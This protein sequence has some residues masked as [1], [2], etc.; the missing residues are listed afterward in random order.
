M[1][2][3]IMYSALMMILM[4]F[5]VMQ[6]SNAF[7][8][9][10]I[11]S[12]NASSYNEDFQ[13]LQQEALMIAHGTKTTVF[14][15]SDN[16]VIE[17]SLLGVTD[18]DPANVRDLTSYFNL[19]ND[20]YFIKLEYLFLRPST[21]ISDG[22]IVITN[23]NRVF[24][25]GQ[26]Y[27][28]KLGRGS[29]SEAGNVL[30]PKVVDLPFESNESIIKIEETY[31]TTYLLTSF[32]RV[33]YTGIGPNFTPNKFQNFSLSS[34]SGLGPNELFVDMYAG[35]NTVVL[36]TNQQQF[37]VLGSNQNNLFLEGASSFTIPTNMT[38]TI[39]S[40]LNED[41][42]VVKMMLK[43]N[44]FVFYTN[45][46]RIFAKGQNQ[47]GVFGTG[48][49]DELV[50]LTDITSAYVSSSD[51]I[52]DI[53]LQ[54]ESLFSNDRDYFVVLLEDG[55]LL[56]SGRN[57][58]F[59]LDDDTLLFSQ[60]PVDISSTFISQTP[61]TDKITLM[62]SSQQSF[63][64]KTQ[65]NKHFVV[66][67]V[68]SGLNFENQK[69]PINID[70]KLI[71]S[72]DYDIPFQVE[73][74]HATT[75][76]SVLITKNDEIYSAGNGNFRVLLDG[77]SRTPISDFFSGNT[78]L[79]KNISSFEIKKFDSNSVSSGLL[80]E[81]GTLVTWGRNWSSF[82]YLVNPFA[83]SSQQDIEFF[84]LTSAFDLNENEVIIDYS[85]STAGPSSTLVYNSGVITNTGRIFHW[86]NQ[87]QING[88][89]GNQSIIETSLLP[90]VTSQL[91]LDEIPVAFLDT[92]LVLTNL[93]R[94]IDISEDGIYDLN[95]MN[96][97]PNDEVPIKYEN[98]YMLSDANHLYKVSN[99][100]TD[101]TQDI[102]TAINSAP[103]LDNSTNI[104]TFSFFETRI[105]GAPN[106]GLFVISEQ[107]NLYEIKADY[108]VNEAFDFDFETTTDFLK[109]VSV[110][111]S[112]DTIDSRHVL[113]LTHEGFVY[114]FGANAEGQLGLGNTTSTTEF[115]LVNTLD[116]TNLYEVK[117]LQ[118]PKS[119][120]YT[121]TTIPLTILFNQDLEGFITDIKINDT[122]YPVSSFTKLDAFTYS[123]ELTN[124]FQLFDSTSVTVSQVKLN[125][126]SIKDLTLNNTAFT[127][128]VAENRRL[129]L[130]LNGGTVFNLSLMS[131]II[132]EG[133][134]LNDLPTPT[135]Q[136]YNFVGW[137]EDETL[138]TEFTA[139]T[140]PMQDTTL[141]AKWDEKEYNLIFK[142]ENGVNNAAEI[143]RI[144][145]K[146]GTDMSTVIIPD[147]PEAIG[148][149]FQRWINL[150]TSTMPTLD[151]TVVADFDINSYEI[152]FVTNLGETGVGDVQKTETL[153]FNVNISTQR[154]GISANDGYTFMGWY[155]TEDFST[156]RVT[157][158]PASDTTL[159]AQ[160]LPTHYRF[161]YYN[162]SNGFL[163]FDPDSP[164]YL[165]GD[166][167]SS[168]VTPDSLTVP[169][170]T[171]L[172]W[173]YDQQRTKEIDFSAPLIAQ[174]IATN[175]VTVLFVYAKF[176]PLDYNMTFVVNGGTNI[177]PEIFGFG[178][179][180]S[181]LPSPTKEGYTFTGWYTDED[182]ATAF[183]STTMPS[184]D[185]V[186]YAKYETGTFD[187][188]FKDRL[189]EILET[190]SFLFETDL[191]SVVLPTPPQVLGYTFD[192]WSIELPNIMPGNDLEIQA[193]YTAKIHTLTLVINNGDNNVT[194][195]RGYN[196]DLAI[197]VV[198][199]TGY[200]FAG[201][202]TNIELDNVLTFDVMP[203]DN[204]TLYAKW[205]INSY[206][207]SFDSNDGSVV[208]P[209]T[210]VYDSVVVA[211]DA[212]TRVGFTF[213]GWFS[214]DALTTAFTFDKVPAEN[215]TLYAKWDINSYTIS[216]ELDGGQIN[217]QQIVFTVESEPFEITAATKTNFVFKGWYTDENF[218]QTITTFNPLLNPNDI[219]LYALYIS[220]TLDEFITDIN[221]L[222]STIAIEDKE[223]VLEY[224]AI[225][226][227]LE[228]DEQALIPLERLE[229]ALEEIST[230]EINRVVNVIEEQKE[231]VTLEDESSLKAARELYETLTEEEKALVTNID[232]LESK[233]AI[234]EV[235]KGID[236]VLSNENVTIEDIEEVLIVYNNLTEEQK[237][238][239]D[240][241]AL[242]ALYELQDS[243]NNTSM[244]IFV[245]LL[246]L[247]LL[248]AAAYSYYRFVYKK[249]IDTNK[250]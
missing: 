136:H 118:I 227:T 143:T 127:N 97:L 26:E 199:K 223:L 2:K 190:Q 170:G 134:T 69:T 184:S 82:G 4:S 159:Y 104:K 131:Y 236:T 126:G 66:G 239:V 226:N 14:I 176:I 245:W 144:A 124:E 102:I 222:P 64:V 8:R 137:Y 237:N 178:D 103:Y 95:N 125:D 246:L 81:D 201:W 12:E 209:I 93:G 175:E 233:E 3:K 71:I 91:S 88:S 42:Y 17:A 243:M 92:F 163:A 213:D 59:L 5:T 218:E 162:T 15:S 68:I 7:F 189:G 187:L 250:K 114:S 122:F 228:E 61:S 138:T 145:V 220:S 202:Y 231:N 180:L 232:I 235:L 240:Q 43:N 55:S 216:F 28:N 83:T 13:Q 57:G 151:V 35:S 98:T 174:P 186:L 20:E 63:L 67:N 100:V 77:G 200:T 65:E 21:S 10:P 73:S 171:R 238:S 160:W 241:Q 58:R 120:Y 173:F 30:N 117:S 188:V 33:Y 86:G 215:I 179:D 198:T 207:I 153:Q 50:T 76:R 74:V 123:I 247:I 53:L 80:M 6:E 22:Y 208:A 157:N 129:T 206:T 128:L 46:N 146:H 165:A 135:L 210:Q 48:D 185:I 78:L 49:E 212:P 109:S 154:Y 51:V 214:D 139:T 219:V 32:G 90:K 16:R 225:Y 40:D 133:S 75:S 229:T 119:I 24:T 105:D 152:T 156:S 79:K 60:T 141:Y 158:V 142:Y 19:A 94:F 25:W 52:V 197:D 192:R 39:T 101:V 169:E 244:S 150:P 107:G 193:L 34:V 224:L 191:S 99:G 56:F 140:M 106:I 115:N 121:Q 211:P 203:D 148:Y 44:K 111:G 54:E 96:A 234:Y 205:D 130:D 183:T 166:D 89:T 249:S 70:S 38:S 116:N 108:S 217:E 196:S 181:A 110:G 37:Y 31:S 230:L 84:N 172:G 47:N 242:N 194:I 248:A 18:F 195:E 164:T 147:D 45:E 72:R 62:R 168:E 23:L 155:L 177:E 27:S 113:V 11:V 161:Y 132:Q 204:L 41:E 36:Q 112:N 87:Q 149:T 9:E 85:T 167:I 29:T 1:M 221:D 182:L